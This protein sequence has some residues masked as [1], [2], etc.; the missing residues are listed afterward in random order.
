MLYF[1]VSFTLIA[2][3]PTPLKRQELTNGRL[4][5]VS[6]QGAG[7]PSR[8]VLS[9][10]RSGLEGVANSPGFVGKVVGEAELLFLV[11]ESATL[12]ECWVESTV[13]LLSSLRPVPSLQGMLEQGP[14]QPLSLGVGDQGSALPG[15]LQMPCA[16][17]LAQEPVIKGHLVCSSS[18]LHMK[19]KAEF[20][21]QMHLSTC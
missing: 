14:G 12:Q 7:L 8:S 9:E 6:P 17:C 1:V 5:A 2:K 19:S 21:L 4:S 10:Q 20:F 18:L 11:L 15:L 3:K 13:P 16:Q